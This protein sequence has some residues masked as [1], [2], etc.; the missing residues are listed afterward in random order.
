V[1]VQYYTDFSF[2]AATSELI[3]ATGVGLGISPPYLEVTF[4]GGVPVDD[5]TN[6][7]FKEDGVL[8]IHNR[9]DAN[10]MLKSVAAT[11][12]FAV[13]GGPADGTKLSPDSTFP[14][15]IRFNPTA[16]GSRTGTVTVTY[17]TDFQVS[18][19]TVTISVDGIGLVPVID[20]TGDIYFGFLSVP[21]DVG[22]RCP[23]PFQKE[24]VFFISSKGE[25]NLNVTGI[26]CTGDCD[27]FTIISPPTFPEILQPGQLL[28]VR[29]RFNPTVAGERSATFHVASNAGTV[30]FDVSGTGLQSE[31]EFTTRERT[32]VFGPTVVGFSGQCSEE[33]VIAFINKG[34]GC[35]RVDDISIVGEGSDAFT[36]VEV[37]GTPLVI[38]RGEIV[39]IKVKFTPTHVGKME[40]TLV[41]NTNVGSSTLFL[42]GEGV[43]TGLRLL[44]YDKNS[45][46]LEGTSKDDLKNGFVDRVQVLSRALKPSVRQKFDKDDLTLK[47]VAG[48]SQEED[49]EDSSGDIKFHLETQLP[50]TYTVGN[51]SSSYKVNV[52]FYTSTYKNSQSNN[53]TIQLPGC[54]GFKII[55]IQA[56]K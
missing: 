41:V 43:N 6:P 51:A 28:P 35:L 3:G 13:I 36:I 26:T 30:D 19:A 22:P 42:C 32:I 23:L 9:G 24:E 15:T 21:D 50:A 5:A 38:G 2:G 1:I 48:C 56:E 18:T 37:P 10:L 29:I 27:D 17:Y 4:F 33:K 45:N 14:V 34:P 25:A 7:V 54:E 55:N 16:G 11:G 40:A 20:V 49:G 47:E 8:Q 52:R 12:D 39:V 31:L 44:V 46:L 53:F